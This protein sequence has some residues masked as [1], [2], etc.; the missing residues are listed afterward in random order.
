[1]R[2][3]ISAFFV[4]AMTAA[5]ANNPTAP[6]ATTGPLTVRI[7]AQC[8]AVGTMSADLYIDGQYTTAVSAGSSWTGTVSVGSHNIEAA[9]YYF[10]TGAPQRHWGPKSVNVPAAGYTELFYCS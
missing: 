6:T 9:A 7:D 10:S 1:M 2:R 5:C 4:A 8:I 3:S